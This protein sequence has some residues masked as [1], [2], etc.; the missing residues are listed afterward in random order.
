MRK[1]LIRFHYTTAV[2]L[3]KVPSLTPILFSRDTTELSI[4]C[5]LATASGLD[6]S[7]LG[8]LG[9][10]T[11][12]SLPLETLAFAIQGSIKCRLKIF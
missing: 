6:Q 5:G 2:F 7:S 10:P 1:L 11:I 12:P 4:V 3:S 9:S 8:F